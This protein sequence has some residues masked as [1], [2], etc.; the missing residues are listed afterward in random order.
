VDHKS[1]EKDMKLNQKLRF[2]VGVLPNASWKELVKRFK[3]VEELGFDITGTGDHFVDG[4]RPNDPWFE[5][6]TLLAAIAMETTR[7]R[8]GSYVTQIPFRN[9]ALL[10]RQAL[11]IDHISNGR[12]EL[13]LG[14]GL[15][16][17]PACEIMGIPN[18]SKKERVARFKEYVEIVDQLL[19]NEVTTY[20]GRYYEVKEAVMNPRPVQKPRPPITIAALGSIMLKYAVRYA[21]TWNSLSWGNTFEEQLEETRGRIQLVHKYCSE[22]GRA[23]SSLRSSYLMLDSQAR[24][25]GGLINYYDS[26]KVFADMVQKLVNLG[27][28]D[29][30]LYYPFREE[31]LSMFR[32]IAKEVIPELKEKY[33]R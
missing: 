19:S 6:W 10:A 4:S 8:L 23:P 5:L 11:A 20:K 12:L 1:I 21:D 9:P 26:E 27:I 7:I 16:A 24:M 22:I 28:T 32:K 2:G 3:H 29:F 14:T 33:N 13:G 30:L 17:D 31:Q 15:I 18:W 25:R